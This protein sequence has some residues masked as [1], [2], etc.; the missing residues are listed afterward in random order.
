LNEAE[1]EVNWPGEGLAAAR[2]V[3]G[4]GKRFGGKLEFELTGG[5]LL[6]ISGGWLADDFAELVEDS[7]Y[8]HLPR[9]R[10]IWS[11]NAAVGDKEEAWCRGYVFPAVASSSTMMGR[12]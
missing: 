12:Q 4:G 2:W 11:S 5:W 10:P 9:W 6:T 7:I 8:R 3:H 1:E